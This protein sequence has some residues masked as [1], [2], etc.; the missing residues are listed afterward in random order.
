MI[1]IEIWTRLNKSI[2]TKHY[3]GPNQY[4]TLDEFIRAEPKVVTRE[5]ARPVVKEAVKPTAK[6]KPKAVG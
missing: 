1:P 2:N 5:I 3:I 6:P 4:K